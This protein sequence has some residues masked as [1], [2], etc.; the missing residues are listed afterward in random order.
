MS[1]KSSFKIYFRV[2]QKMTKYIKNR[3][4]KFR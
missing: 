2:L 4:I 3:I 1:Q